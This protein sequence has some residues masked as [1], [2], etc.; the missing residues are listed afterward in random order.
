MAKYR[1]TVNGLSENRFMELRY[2]C[3]QYKTFVAKN[4]GAAKMIEQAATAADDE[5]Y[6]FLIMN[7]SEGVAFGVL[8]D[9]HGMPCGKGRFYSSKRRFFRILDLMRG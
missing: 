7:A 4:R 8:R 3:M 2:F 5:L 9:V 6:K 1:L